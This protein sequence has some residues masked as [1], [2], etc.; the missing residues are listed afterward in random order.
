M[1][2][3][4]GHKHC[5]ELV[6]LGGQSVGV[7]SLVPPR[8][9]KDCTHVPRLG[10]KHLYL[11]SHPRNLGTIHDLSMCLFPEAEKLDLPQEH[12]CLSEAYC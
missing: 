1:C 11:R 3:G 9:S 2:E 4:L 8:K 7:S 12:L 5:G 6:E 10:S